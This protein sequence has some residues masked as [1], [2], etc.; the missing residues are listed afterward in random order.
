MKGLIGTPL[1]IALR[2]FN[3]A[4]KTFRDTVATL[5]NEIL[6]D[7][8]RMSMPAIIVSVDEYE[9][10]QSIDVKPLVNNLYKDNIAVEYPVIYGVPVVLL[11]GGG[12]LISVPLKVGDTVKLEF[13]RDSLQEFLGS[14]GET[15]VTPADFR[16]YSLTDA[17]ATP[18]LPTRSNTLNPNPTDVEIKFLDD[19]GGELSSIKMKPDGDLT[20]DT[21][22]D[23]IATV[24]GECNINVTGDC[25]INSSGE[26]NIDAS[27]V[28]LGSGGNKIARLGD[29][30]KVTVIGGSSS[31]VHTGSITAAGNNTS[32]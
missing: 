9:S 26:C 30:V 14:S 31:G 25:N 15:E 10:A 17:I 6:Q 28:N 4:E 24:G 21:K 27:Q 18:M 12:A 19:A 20:V 5:V 2:L 1:S 23:L 3:M 11:G 29:Q 16:R 8:I 22:K 7:N 13:S 32:T